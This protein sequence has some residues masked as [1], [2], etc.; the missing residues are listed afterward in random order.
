MKLFL[1][2]TSETKPIVFYASILQRFF[3]LLVKKRKKL[4]FFLTKMKISFY[5]LQNNLIQ[6][7]KHFYYYFKE[8]H[9]M[10]GCMSFVCMCR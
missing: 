5:V 6:K 4:D 1:T 3:S 7:T 10:N 2:K 9:L 8:W